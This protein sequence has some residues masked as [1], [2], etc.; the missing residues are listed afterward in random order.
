[1]TATAANCRPTPTFNCIPSA[2]Y[3][4][5]I[6]DFVFTSRCGTDYA[7]QD[8]LGLYMYSFDDCIEACANWNEQA[9]GRN[10]SCRAISYDTTMS[11]P[12][13]N[14]FLK[15]AGVDARERASADSA[16]L[17]SVG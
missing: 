16:V 9:A 3:T 17:E 12:V 1:M 8:L 14:C 5:Q 11:L 6:T 7:G 10:A 4:A 2:T 15:P 13:G